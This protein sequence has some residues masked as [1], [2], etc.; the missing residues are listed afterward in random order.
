MSKNRDLSHF[1]NGITVDGSNNH[2]GIGSLTPVTE[3]EVS[4][5]IR[6]TGGNP[7]L[8][9]VLTCDA[10]GIGSW[11]ISSASGTLTSQSGVIGGV[12]VTVDQVGGN[13]VVN[14][15]A[16]SSQSGIIGVS[17]ITVQQ[18]GGSFV[19]DGALS[20]NT[21][22]INFLVD[23]SPEDITTGI[24]GY[25]QIPY[26]CEVIEWYVLARQSGT[27]VFDVRSCDFNNYPATT[28]IVSGDYPLVSGQIQNSNLAVSW[29]PLYAAQLLEFNVI[30]NSVQ[31]GVQTANLFLKTRAI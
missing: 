15:A 23:A 13:F 26:N 9:K 30:S 20:H 17:G 28:S 16:S 10:S 2:V 27:M 25:T 24:K 31:S 21:N 1:P 8:G 12:G 22:T 29:S 18:I 7:A 6:I 4:G 11:E 19:I 3:L 5:Q 14:A